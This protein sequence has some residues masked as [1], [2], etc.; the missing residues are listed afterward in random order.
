[1]DTG[2]DF[3]TQLVSNR[4]LYGISALKALT[5]TERGRYILTHDQ[6]TGYF[7]HEH[8]SIMRERLDYFVKT[9]ILNSEE[10]NTLAPMC[11]ELIQHL[12]RLKNL[13]YK[14]IMK[15]NYNETLVERME[16]II[17]D[18]EKFFKELLSILKTK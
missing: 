14:N 11:D 9:G 16:V 6:R 12:I 5:E 18:E 7:L 15:E 10:F 3:C 1:R 8:V 13:I 2:E 17:S 4:Y